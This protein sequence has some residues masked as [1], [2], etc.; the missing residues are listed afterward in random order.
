MKPGATQGKKNIPQ[1]KFTAKVPPAAKKE[2]PGLL[3]RLEQYFYSKRK[4]YFILSCILTVLFSILLFDVKMSNAH[5]DSMY[6]QA[7]Y[8][9]TQDIRNIYAANAPLYSLLLSIPISIFGLK[10]ILLKSLSVTFMLMQIIFL[11][12]AFKDRVSDAALFLVL[13]TVSVNS[14]FLYFASQTFN[15]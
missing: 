6:V 13:L 9:I 15:E 8:K 11:Y 7:G 12:L 4:F 10:I 14:Y 1:K 2:Q 3:T 5:D